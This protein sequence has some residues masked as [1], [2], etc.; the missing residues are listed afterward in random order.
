ML[1]NIILKSFFAD[2]WNLFSSL[3][4]C[5]SESLFYIPSHHWPFCRQCANISKYPL[6][7]FSICRA[8]SSVFIDIFLNING[9]MI[10]F[11]PVFLPA[12]L[13]CAMYFKPNHGSES[14]VFLPVFLWTVKMAIVVWASEPPL[15]NER[16][17]S[18]SSV[19]LT[20][21]SSGEIEPDQ[22]QMG[23]SR[24]PPNLPS[25]VSCGS[26]YAKVQAAGGPVGSDSWRGW[27]LRSQAWALHCLVLRV[28]PWQVVGA[29]QEAKEI[30]II[31]FIFI[32]RRAMI[33]DH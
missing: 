18:A 16:Y 21:S 1:R 7:V 2:W 4:F 27:S 11:F 9:Q 23:G 8:L 33:C 24:N 5:L 25:P 6:W 31:I 3:Q 30:F 20:H 15:E 13:L 19:T 28:K 29:S 32:F 26:V 10:F 22:Q 14:E 17:S 12:H